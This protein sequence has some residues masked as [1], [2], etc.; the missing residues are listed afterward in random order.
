MVRQTLV[1]LIA[2]ML[3]VPLVTRAETPARVYQPR[4]EIKL[5]K[6]E[7]VPLRGRYHLYLV[8]DQQLPGQFAAAKGGKRLLIGRTS[9]D[10]TVLLGTAQLQGNRVY[11]SRPAIYRA[12]IRVSNY[13]EKS[14]VA[15]LPSNDAKSPYPRFYTVIGPKDGKGPLL[16]QRRPSQL[17]GGKPVE[18]SILGL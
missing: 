11:H 13:T 17:V 9:N 18:Y 7:K 12:G 5:S 3:F 8:R 16:I 4:P 15:F 1:G 14:V 10:G 2:A 6:L